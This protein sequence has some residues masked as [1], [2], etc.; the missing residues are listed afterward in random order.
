MGR[1]IENIRIENFKSLKDMTL[2]ACR[3]YNLL[4]GRPNVGK[5]NILEALSL[6]SVPY[7]LMEKRELNELLR[8]QHGIPR[9]C[10]IGQKHHDR[11][12]VSTETYPIGHG[13]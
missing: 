10:R 13:P 1:I 5:S 8:F 6:F 3:S 2:K 11:L 7:L 12:T 9:G 4:L